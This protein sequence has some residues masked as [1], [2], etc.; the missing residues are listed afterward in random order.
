MHPLAFPSL[1]A[2]GLLLS[3]P[4]GAT[5]VAFTD[6][7]CPV[8]PD[9]VVRVYEKLSA[10][11]HGGFDSDGANYSSKGQFR[12]YAVATC[13]RTLFSLYGGD[14]GMSLTEGDKARLLGALVAARAALDD[15]ANPTVW[16]R[17]AIAAAMYEQLGRGQLFLADL[18]IEASWTARDEAVGVFVGLRGPQAARETLRLGEAELKKDLPQAARKTLIYNLARVAHRGGY[19]AERDRWLAEFE[20][21]SPHSADEVAALARFRDIAGR[22]EPALQDRAI[23]HLRAGLAQRELAPETRARSAYLLADLLR[24]RGQPDEA[25]GLYNTVLSEERAPRELRELALFLVGELRG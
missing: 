22:V 7:P 3:P 1:L 25:L 15:P 24:R 21:L 18:W 19:S 6:G 17:Y 13:A 23:T 9:D 14:M 20:A 11:T 4:A 10:N 12:T 5:Q 16:E 2:L 8:D